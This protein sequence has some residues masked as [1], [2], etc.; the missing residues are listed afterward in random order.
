MARF[1]FFVIRYLDKIYHHFV[2]KTFV[3]RG[4]KATLLVPHVLV[5]LKHN[6]VVIV[7]II[8]PAKGV[9]P[10]TFFFAILDILFSL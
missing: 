1:G 3:S 9:S 2:A 6:Q 8:M 4:I 5:Q 10:P 7:A